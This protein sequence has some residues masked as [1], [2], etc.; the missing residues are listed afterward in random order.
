MDRLLARQS[1]I[2]R[3]LTSRHLKEGHLVLYDIT[4]SYLEG[5]YTQS[6][7]VTFGYDR[8]G[9]RGHEQMVVALLCNSQ[10]C[11]VGVEVFAGNTQDASTVPGKDRAIAE[12]IQLER[13]YLCGRS[14]HDYPRGDSK[15]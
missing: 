2:Q 12:S 3:T 9:K 15:D 13:D 8:D 1:A 5:A 14:R 7:I 4:S 6:D 10:G 11:P